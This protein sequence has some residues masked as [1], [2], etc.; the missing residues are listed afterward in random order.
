MHLKIDMCVFFYI[1][2]VM[3]AIPKDALYYRNVNK[4][5][6]YNKKKNYIQRVRQKAFALKIHN[7]YLYVPMNRFC[8]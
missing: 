2:A 8:F 3:C 1:C 7:V 5:Q 6:A 4:L